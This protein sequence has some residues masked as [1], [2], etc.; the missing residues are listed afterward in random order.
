MIEPNGTTNTGMVVYDIPTFNERVIREAVLNAVSHRNYQLAGSIF[1]HQYRNRLVLE[2]PGGFSLG[3]TP[4]NILYRQAPRNK[5]IAVIFV[6][7]CIRCCFNNRKFKLRFF[8]SN[9]S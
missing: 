4:E 7:K 3:I 1:V 5:R 8:Y 9:R 6:V 2:S